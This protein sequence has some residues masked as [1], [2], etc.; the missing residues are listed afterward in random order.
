MSNISK[1]KCKENRRK[2]NH[3]NDM[4]Y[5][6]E[7]INNKRSHDP[8]NRSFD[9]SKYLALNSLKFPTLFLQLEKNP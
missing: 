8:V 9:F 3:T 6:W 4:K 5:K 1:N 7:S 2:S